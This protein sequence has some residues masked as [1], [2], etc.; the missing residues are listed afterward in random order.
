MRDRQTKYPW[1]KWLDGRT[2]ELRKGRDYESTLESLRGRASRA[3]SQRG[4]KVKTRIIRDGRGEGIAIRAYEEGETFE[5]QEADRA[6]HHLLYPWHEWLN[7]QTWELRQGQHFEGP[8]ERLRRNAWLRARRKG[9]KVR[10]RLVRGDADEGDAGEGL[11]IRAYEEG[12]EFYWQEA[13]RPGPIAIY[14]WDRWLN[15]EAWELQR[16]RDYETPTERFRKTAWSAAHS[17]GKKLKTRLVRDG[18]AE[19]LVIRAYEA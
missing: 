1:D 13:D 8:A 10:T 18:G 7:G 15:G 6:S 16:G 12:E 9:K 2:W 19:R 17:K 5:W 11:V 4:K 3:A 14:P